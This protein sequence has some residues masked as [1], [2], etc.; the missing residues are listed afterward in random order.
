[1][2]RQARTIVTHHIGKVRSVT[3]LSGGLNNHVFRVRA[4][5]GNVVVRLSEAGGKTEAFLKEQ[6]A[7]KRADEAGV[8]VARILQVG[9]DVI[10]TPYMILE[11]ATGGVATDHAEPNKILRRLGELTSRIHGIETNGFGA[12]F[13]WSNNA[14]SRCES[15]HD[16]LTDEFTWQDRLAI[17]DKAGCLAKGGKQRL[18]SVM[19]ALARHAPSPAL[20]HGDLRLKNVFVDAKGKITALMDWEDCQSSA[21]RY[22]DLPL[23]LHDLGP[24]GRQA[25]LDGYGLPPDNT[26]ELS[27]GWTAFNLLHYAPKVAQVV[28]QRDEAAL[29]W[30]RAR[31]TGALDLFT[32]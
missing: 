2:A 24:D 5:G 14:L 32:L 10:E 11:N 25:F 27:A 20:N 30:F 12:T 19:T 8:P 28:A 4:D 22:W 18:R 21:P 15:W 17:L 16:F 6:W 31:L 26:A 29:A 23:A 13:D 9:S 3:A 7:V 1:M